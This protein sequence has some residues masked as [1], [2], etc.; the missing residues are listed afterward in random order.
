MVG[1]LFALTSDP[2]VA[3]AKD[4]YHILINLSAD[5][6]LHQVRSGAAGQ[7][8]HRLDQRLD[9][10]VKCLVSRPGFSVGR[11][12]SSGSVEEASGSRL[13]VLRPDLHHPVQ[14]DAPREDLQ[15]GVQGECG[16]YPLTL[17]QTEVRNIRAK[18]FSR[19]DVTSCCCSSASFS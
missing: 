15:D 18:V 11:R 4:C 2:S 7:D 19:S 12:S 8:D 16:I 10:A 9:P 3:I 13:P 1:A 5:E 17:E 6:T 14:P